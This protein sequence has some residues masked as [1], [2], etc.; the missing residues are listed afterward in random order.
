MLE[1]DTLVYTFS[2]KGI[3]RRHKTRDDTIQVAWSAL[4]A[5]YKGDQIHDGFI[6]EFEFKI[7]LGKIGEKLKFTKPYTPFVLY[8]FID[9]IPIKK[10]F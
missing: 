3:I 8:Q 4:R 2:S 9:T 6:D 10:D 1:N 5:S 7:E